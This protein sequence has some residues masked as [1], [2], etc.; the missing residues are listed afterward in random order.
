MRGVGGRL[1]GS[2][3]KVVKCGVLGLLAV[4]MKSKFDVEM[5][6]TLMLMV[7]GHVA[8]LSVCGNGI[9]HPV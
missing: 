1:G 7:N 5:V 8:R 3:G 6:L 2:L 4:L 9:C